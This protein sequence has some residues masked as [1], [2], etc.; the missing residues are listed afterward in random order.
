M[1]TAYC[2]YCYKAFTASD[3]AT[4]QEMRDAHEAVCPERKKDGR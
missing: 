4:A 1:F 3:M 2:G